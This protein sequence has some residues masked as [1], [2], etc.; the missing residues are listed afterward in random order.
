[1][2]LQ[3]QGDSNAIQDFSIWHSAPSG[4]GDIRLAAW[5]SEARKSVGSAGRGTVADRSL[6]P[7]K[8]VSRGCRRNLGYIEAK[9]R[10]TG[11]IDWPAV[12]RWVMARLPLGAGNGFAAQKQEHPPRFLHAKLCRF[13]SCRRLFIQAH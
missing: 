4:T 7:W 6:E 9:A 13:E 8:V 11:I 3:R 12:R 10:F 2:E 1:M 5:R